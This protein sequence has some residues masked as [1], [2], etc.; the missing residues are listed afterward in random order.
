MVNHRRC[1]FN[2]EACWQIVY[3]GVSARVS[4]P[5][6]GRLRAGSP[7]GSRVQ[8]WRCRAPHKHKELRA[9]AQAR[10]RELRLP[11]TR[12]PGAGALAGAGAANG[13]LGDLGDIFSFR[14]STLF[15]T[16]VL[17]LAPAVQ[18]TETVSFNGPPTLLA[19]AHTASKQ[20]GA[21]AWTL[22]LGRDVPAMT[23]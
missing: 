10:Q 22:R 2:T 15:T 21:C 9:V 13:G 23:P 18:P 7:I 11:I 4:M 19:D 16:I 5:L 17:L 1:R 14:R 12:A 3:A 6:R 8:A 20:R